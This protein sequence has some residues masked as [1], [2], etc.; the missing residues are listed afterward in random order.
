MH[1]IT[2]LKHRLPPIA[3]TPV[4]VLYVKDDLYCL[5]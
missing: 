3:G 2:N 1:A 5:M 4:A